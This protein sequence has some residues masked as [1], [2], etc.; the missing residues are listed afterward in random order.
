MLQRAR[1]PTLPTS[2][3]TV[4]P[5]LVSQRFFRLGPNAVGRVTHMRFF[6]TVPLPH[7]AVD[8]APNDTSDSADQVDSVAPSA[9]LEQSDT[10]P[11]PHPTPIGE[12]K[13][14]ITA[15]EAPPPAMKELLHSLTDKNVDN[16][17]NS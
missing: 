15:S 8:Q 17:D 13:E 7:A 4:R 16:V 1:R 2:L 12:E 5:P 10:P 11:P 9:E 6:G 3:Q 14:K